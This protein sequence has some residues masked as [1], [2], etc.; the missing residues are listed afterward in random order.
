MKKAVKEKDF[1]VNLL[2]S[3]N[4]TKEIFDSKIFKNMNKKSFF[5]NVGR[6]ETVNEKDLENA[7]KKNQIGGAG[8]DV[9][10]NEPFNKS[11]SLLKYNNVIITPHIAAINTRYKIE[12][13]DLFINNYSKFLKNKKLKFLVK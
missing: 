8:L 5:I 13:V 9:V 3:T 2:P 12:Q 4:K 7:I 10:Q 1:V 11:L 6:G